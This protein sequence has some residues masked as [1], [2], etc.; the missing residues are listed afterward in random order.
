MNFAIVAATC[1][2]RNAKPILILL[3]RKVLLVASSDEATLKCQSLLW[4]KERKENQILFRAYSDSSKST[5]Q[6]NLNLPRY[7]RQLI[8]QSQCIYNDGDGDIMPSTGFSLTQISLYRKEMRKSENSSF[9]RK[10]PI[11]NVDVHS[12]IRHVIQ[13][14]LCMQPNLKQNSNTKGEHFNQSQPKENQISV[15]FPQSSF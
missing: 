8:P 14:K 6:E 7:S 5:G 3:Q 13:I 2:L 9:L 11:T 10:F 4:D 15:V 1:L 12:I